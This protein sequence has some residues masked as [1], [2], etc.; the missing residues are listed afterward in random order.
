MM[1]KDIRGIGDNRELDAYM[2]GQ[3]YV[4]RKPKIVKPAMN[5]NVPVHKPT[6]SNSQRIQTKANPVGRHKQEA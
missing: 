2:N 1:G 3:G 6:S 4:P 5:C